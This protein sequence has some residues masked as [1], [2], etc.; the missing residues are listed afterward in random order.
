MFTI[1]VFYHALLYFISNIFHT[2]QNFESQ[3]NSNGTWY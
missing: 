3:K 1:L 2:V